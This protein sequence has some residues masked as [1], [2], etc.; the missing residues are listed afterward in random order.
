MRV[1]PTRAYESLPQPKPKGA[2]TS[3]VATVKTTKQPREDY[4]IGRRSSIYDKEDDRYAMMARPVSGRSPRLQKLPLANYS[5]VRV[6]D[7]CWAR[8]RSGS[9]AIFATTIRTRQNS[10]T[11][12]G[13]I[14]S[15]SNTAQRVSSRARHRRRISVLSFRQSERTAK[16]TL[17][18]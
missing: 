2:A 1:T 7:F 5:V 4:W 9:C 18:N 15:R 6:R 17:L 12:F 8:E 11:M 3:R 16:T 14:H 13:C 10:I